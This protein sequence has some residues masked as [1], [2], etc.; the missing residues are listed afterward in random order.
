[1]TIFAASLPILV[2]IVS[3]VYFRWNGKQAGLAGW[4]VGAGISIF[5]FG[6]DFNGL[7][8][9][10][11]RG[12]Y[13]AIFVLAII[14][15]ALALY[16]LVDQAGG[17]QAIS[18]WFSSSVRN[19]GLLKV[20]LAWAF[21]GMLEGLAGFGLPV[22]IVSPLLVGMGVAPISAVAAVAVGHSWSV[23]FG[24][25]G[26]IFQTLVAITGFKPEL[27]IAPASLMLGFSCLACGWGAMLILRQTNLWRQIGLL[28]LI[29]AFTQYGFAQIGLV[30]LSAFFAG[31]AGMICLLL[32]SRG[33]LWRTQITPPL[34]AAVLSY[35]SLALI[36]ILITVVPPIH[37]IVKSVNLSFI[38][39]SVVTSAGYLTPVSKQSLSILLYPGT[40]L[41]L[42][43]LISYRWHRRRG[44][45]GITHWHSIIQKTLHSALPTSIGIM[46]MVGL[47]SVMDYSGMMQELARGLSNT[48]GG[49]Y[50]LISPWIGILGAFAT[51]SNNNSN[52]LFA[53]LQTNIA[54]M[55]DLKPAI[56]LAA[57]TTGGALGS[58]LA[59]AKII[60]GCSTVGL[61]DGQGQVM[62]LTLGFGIG[63]GLLVGF[64]SL[65]LA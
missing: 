10:Q 32:L 4:M 34:I 19:S 20:G 11:L 31:L 33:N 56:I 15:P 3:M 54:Q 38:F 17:I 18:N 57:Q 37:Q 55:L 65:I 41:G 63:I 50:P 13:L 62:R 52:V 26:V 47:A 12:L 27:L 6:L 43:F 2:V 21:S 5:I 29:M 46:T 25:M 22:A 49:L 40:I 35:G 8:V 42:V 48:S 44:L 28:G 14:W 51:G 45:F 58:M 61:R 30:P 39:P 9:S 36:L 60:V 23:T 59:P 24:D 16:H 64:I 53:Q 7:A 1:M